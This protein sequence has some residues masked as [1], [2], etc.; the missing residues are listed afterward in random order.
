MPIRDA[1]PE[2]APA[3]RVLLEQAF[4]GEQE[5]RLVDELRRD[6][7]LAVAQ[8]SEHDGLT[9]GYIALC[10]MTSP[11]RSLA[12]APAAQGR[13][14]GSALVRAALTRARGL[15]CPIVF[16]VGE[17]TYYSRF[18]FTPEAAAPFPCQYAGPHFLAL[19]L[20]PDPIP[21]ES[22]GYAPC[23]RQAWLMSPG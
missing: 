22:V 11:A 19:R 16:V 10:R 1:R 6:G 12:L 13:G 7:D 4:G 8:V 17:G 5:A 15:D 2:D 3:I 18:G 21:P 20:A 23:L 9:L 14:T